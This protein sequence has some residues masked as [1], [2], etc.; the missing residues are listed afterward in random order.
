[1]FN[2]VGYVLENHSRSKAAHLRYLVAKKVTEDPINFNEAVVGRADYANYIQQSN[3]WGGAVELAIL[4]AHYRCEICAWDVINVR[5]NVFGE[6]SGF[7]NRVYVLYDV[8]IAASC[9]V[10]TSRHSHS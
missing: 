1:L 5:K 2:A 7:S 4:A 10:T 3:V 8:R 6:G 9:L